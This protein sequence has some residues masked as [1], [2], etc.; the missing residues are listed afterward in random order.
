MT[1]ISR[2]KAMNYATILANHVDVRDSDDISQLEPSPFR[3][4]STETNAS[5]RRELITNWF[6]PTSEQWMRIQETQFNEQKIHGRFHGDLIK[7]MSNWV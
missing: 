4:F 5:R 3:I 1:A 7:E 6:G 2:R